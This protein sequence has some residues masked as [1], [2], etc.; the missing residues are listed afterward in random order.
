MPIPHAGQYRFTQPGRTRI[1]AVYL[2]HLRFMDMDHM[3][4]LEHA[5]S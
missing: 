3:E 1:G 2:M 4:Q 5:R